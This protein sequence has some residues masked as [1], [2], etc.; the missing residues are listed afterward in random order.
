M[1]IGIIGTGFVGTAVFEGMKHAVE[2]L[3]WDKAKGWQSSKSNEPPVVHDEYGG[4]RPDLYICTPVDQ[5]KMEKDK[6]H[7]YSDPGHSDIYYL[8]KHTW[9]PVFIC[10][11]TPMRSDG[12]CDLSIVE[13]VVM[14]ADQ[15]AAD[16]EAWH[17]SQESYDGTP[18]ARRVLVIK[19]TIP[20]GTTKRLND[21]CKHTIVC[22][23]PEFLTERTYIDDFKNQ[24]RIILGGPHE[25]TAVLK[26]LYQKTYP[27]V[28]TTKTSSTIA[29][30]IKYV[31]NCFLATKVSFANEIAQIC[32]KLDID[33][34][35]VVEYATK[36][37]RLGTSHWAVP[38]HDGHLG[39]GGSCFCKDINALMSLA[40]ELGVKTTVM[41][42]A[43]EK[44]LEV[45]PERDWEK[46]KGRA[47]SEEQ[48][49]NTNT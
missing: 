35:K 46:L 14:E 45:R 22:F 33:Y 7:P 12:T 20:P 23:N 47:V 26:Q 4:Y 48:C 44:N 43:W 18:F 8:M 49:L 37:K 24:D 27:N 36:D 15:A 29:E 11:P 25:G 42:A 28:P 6:E 9:G 39:F 10:V 3:A 2:V 40:K 5:I 16:V 19:S 31:T 38:G 34:D 1:N 13:S 17:R 21:K 32:D 30:M 41:D